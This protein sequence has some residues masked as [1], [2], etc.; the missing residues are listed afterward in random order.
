MPTILVYP[1]PYV[2]P[3]QQVIGGVVMETESER[4]GEAHYRGPLVFSW[5]DVRRDAGR[6]GEGTNLVFHEFAH[7]LDMLNGAADGVPL[8]AG[9]LRSRWQRVMAGEFRCLCRSAAHGRPTVLDPYGATNPA[10]FF[11][12]VTECFFDA[13]G[14]LQREHPELY[15]IFR[16][17]FKQDPAERF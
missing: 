6:T 17:Y 1:G 2:A 14:E 4:L 10:E 13:P 12:V 11:A 5:P 9:K 3:D 15:E 7:Q 16:G 8:L